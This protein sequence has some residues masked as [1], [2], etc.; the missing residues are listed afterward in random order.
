MYFLLLS[1]L[2]IVKTHLV[3]GKAPR[4]SFYE[5][6][7]APSDHR[8]IT[9]QDALVKHYPRTAISLFCEWNL[10]PKTVQP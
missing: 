5:L 3:H 7:A 1:L 4:N 9:A 8:R 6:E 10:S 2:A